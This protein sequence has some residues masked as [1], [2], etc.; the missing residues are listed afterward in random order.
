MYEAFVDACYDLKDLNEVWA[1]DTFI[2][3]TKQFLEG[4]MNVSTGK[5][6]QKIKASTLMSM[7]KQLR[8]ALL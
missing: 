2:S 4:L 3:R 1:R 7:Y 8:K 6:E 5:F